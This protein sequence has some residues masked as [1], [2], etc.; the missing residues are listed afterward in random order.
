MIDW[1]LSEMCD[2]NREKELEDALK[3]LVMKIDAIFKHPS[4]GNMES[5][6]YVHGMIYNG[7]NCMEEMKKAKELLEIKD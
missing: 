6:A 4:Y 2:L 3:A 5:I 7:P 1:S